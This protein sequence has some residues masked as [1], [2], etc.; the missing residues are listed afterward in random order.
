MKTRTKRGSPLFR[1]ATQKKKANPENIPRGKWTKKNLRLSV[2]RSYPRTLGLQK[3]RFH[4]KFY[5]FALQSIA[6]SITFVTTP[7]PTVI[8]PSRME[9]LVPSAITVGGNQINSDRNLVTRETGRDLIRQ[10]N[11]PSHVGSSDEKLGPVSS[12]ERL[13]SSTLKK[14]REERKEGEKK[15]K[16]KE[17]QREEKK[18]KKKKTSVGSKMKV[19]AS[20]RV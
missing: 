15:E 10:R 6:Y 13:A 19:S 1:E 17:R 9:N 12:V 16:R 18:R 11:L 14:A 8:P 7:A 2:I 3:K 20:K 4:I 5:F